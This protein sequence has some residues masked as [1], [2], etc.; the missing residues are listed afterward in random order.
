MSTT[1]ESAQKAPLEITLVLP[2]KRVSGEVVDA[3]TFSVRLSFSKRDCPA[4]PICRIVELEFSGETLRQPISVAARVEDREDGASRNFVFRFNDEGGKPIELPPRLN[5]LLNRRRSFRVRPPQVTPV[6]VAIKGRRA[7]VVP[8]KESVEVSPERIQA[9]VELIDLSGT[10]AAVL[11]DNET[12][13]TFAESS[14]ILVSFRIPTV[15]VALHIVALIRN[16]RLTPG[17]VRY[18]IQFD[19]ERTKAFERQQEA[20]LDYV[21]IRQQDICK[22][23]LR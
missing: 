4:L 17:G 14:R 2:D 7:T 1:A 11:V 15:P 9:Q 5:R 20:I 19:T 3:D 23:D 10:G 8:I 6:P 21:L 16:R 13:E 12:E 22:D 18:G